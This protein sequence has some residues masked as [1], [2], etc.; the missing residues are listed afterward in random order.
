MAISLT[1]KNL[2][3]MRVAMVIVSYCLKALDLLVTLRVPYNKMVGS[4]KNLL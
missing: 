4:Y 3:C 2:D 1:G